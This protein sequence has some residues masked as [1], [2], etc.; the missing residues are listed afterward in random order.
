MNRTN[1]SL[2]LRIVI[3]MTLPLLVISLGLSAGAALIFQA[4][5]DRQIDDSLIRETNELQLLSENFSS[6]ES[7]L[8]EFIQ[9]SSPDENEQLL[10][11]VDSKVSLRSGVSGIRLDRQP[12]FLDLVSSVE[13]SELGNFENELGSFRWIAVPV[14]GDQDSGVL[15]AVY[16]VQPQQQQ[17]A[18]ALASF[19]G[20]AAVAVLSAMVIAWFA[21]GKIFRPI[22]SISQSLGSI[23]SSDL[24]TRVAVSGTG[25]EL[26][27]LAQ[28]FNSM[29]DRL[30]V[31]FE[32]QKQF[33]D[34]AGHELRTP[35]TVIR[36]HLDLL[37]KD[38]IGNPGSLEIV[39]DELARM[40]RLVFDLQTLTK[41]NQPGFI[42]LTEVN[43][44]Q[45][46]D[47]LFVKA[48]SLAQRIWVPSDSACD[49]DFKLDRQR[50]TQ[51][52]LQ[53]ADNACKQTKQD[54]HIQL[55][56]ECADD[57]VAFFVADSGPGID[58]E[59]REKIKKR[60]ARGKQ[61]VEQGEGSGLGLAVVEAIAMA[62]GGYLR[63]DESQYDGAWVGIVLPRGGQ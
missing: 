7:L 1:S 40:S 41:S 16:N 29:L 46:N 18:I 56:V 13:T 32:N 61:H 44:N 15:V 10:A 63:F 39:K 62:H 54:Q 5:A 52:V 58:I 9:R 6:A 43:L 49:S 22:Q 55:G 30:Q 3:W 20:M 11:I 4:Q 14:N 60:F 26:D 12:E 36:G 31:A 25:D 21:S 28:E 33:V 37:E 17:T 48:E 57:Y 50:I 42:E 45:L 8:T 51:A 19:S 2:R 27:K 59:Q 38:P 34:D 24:Q 35:L 53:L 47:E 23:D